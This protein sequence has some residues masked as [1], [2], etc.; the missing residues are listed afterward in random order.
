[1]DIALVGSKCREIGHPNALLTLGILLVRI[2][3][4]KSV[5]LVILDNHGCRILTDIIRSV[6]RPT[7]P[8]IKSLGTCPV[9]TEAILQ[10]LDEIALIEE[11]I[12]AVVD[13]VA[14]I[15]AAPHLLVFKVPLVVDGLVTVLIAVILQE[16]P[17]VSHVHL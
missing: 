10:F 11:T 14:V 13:W 17:L 12:G 7:L 9:L 16:L 2:N 1:M 15:L 6:V 8:I 5:S 4:M 3:I